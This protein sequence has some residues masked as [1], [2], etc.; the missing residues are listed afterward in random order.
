MT[1]DDLFFIDFEAS[2]L[3]KKSYPIS[4]GWVKASGENDTFLISPSS[5]WTDWD[6]ESQSIHGLS[7]KTLFDN[8]IDC[9]E[10]MKRLNLHLKGSIA[11]CSSVY[12][13][14]WLRRL[15][16]AS[17]VHEEFQLVNCLHLSIIDEHN[18]H[19]IC[20][21]IESNSTHNPIDDAIALKNA[22]LSLM[23]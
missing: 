21:L 1:V 10:A 9:C 5:D 7:R 12:D 13:I 18:Y 19:R 8:G 11:V 6:V 14:F 16:D 20:R 2:S 15:R 4:A 3:S 22:I 17:E 23:N